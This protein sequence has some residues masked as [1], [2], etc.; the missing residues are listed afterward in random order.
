MSD[1]I[2][3]SSNSDSLSTQPGSSDFPDDLYYEPANAV[4][5]LNDCVKT[6]LPFPDGSVWVFGDFGKGVARYHAD[7]RFD[8][9]FW[10]NIGAGF[11]RTVLDAAIGT[12]GKIWIVGSFNFFNGISCNRTARLLPDGTLDASFNCGTGFDEWA[13]TIHIQA[14][15]KAIIGGYFKEYNGTKHPHLIRLHPDGSV[16]GGFCTGSGF[17]YCVNTIRS[18]A[19]ETLWIGGSFTSYQGKNAEYIIHL[20]SDGSRI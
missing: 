20:H 6:I 9:E 8:L 7:G 17:D 5:T 2:F 12:D 15:G 13:K 10:K 19:E 1:S 11:D 4:P 16:D 3:S 14:D 18:G